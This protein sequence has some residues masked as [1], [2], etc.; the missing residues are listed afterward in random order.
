ME[1][2]GHNS[3]FG[4]TSGA[5]MLAFVE[6]LRAAYPH[7]KIVLVADVVQEKAVERTALGKGLEGNA[8]MWLVA[9]RMDENKFV[10]KGKT[11]TG[12]RLFGTTYLE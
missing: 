7:I 3:R 2:D 12:D 4:G 5:S 1:R 11:N 8:K 9:S 10:G 6:P